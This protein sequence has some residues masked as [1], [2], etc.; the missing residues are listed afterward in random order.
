MLGKILSQHHGFKCTV[1]FSVNDK[2]EIDP[3]NQKS[4]SNPKA[5]ASA[6]AIIM[7]L[8]FRTWSDEDYKHFDDACN[9]GIPVLGLRTSTHAFRET[10][11]FR[12]RVLGEKW[13]SHWGGHKREACRSAI[14]PSAKSNP[15]LNGLTDMFADGDVYEAYPPKDA[16]ILVRGLVL[17]T[18]DP[19][20]SRPLRKKVVV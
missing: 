7:L 11:R 3:N 19:V 6:D 2:G 20:P 16:T 12:Q 15:I 9:R 14:E 5:L 13:V 10:C 4:I 8:R 1:S 18:M 17:E